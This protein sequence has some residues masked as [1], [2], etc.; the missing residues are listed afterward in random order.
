MEKKVI[1]SSFTY[2][3][4]EK[5]ENGIRAKQFEIIDADILHFNNIKSLS[6]FQ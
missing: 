1:V 5:T 2:I 3:L 4:I 6:S